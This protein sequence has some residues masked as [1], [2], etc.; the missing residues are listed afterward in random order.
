MASLE[1]LQ[2]KLRA[3]GAPASQLARIRDLVILAEREPSVLEIFL[4]GSY[5][6]GLGDR[7]SDLDLVAIAAPGCQELVLHATRQVLQS[8]S[9]FDTRTSPRMS[10]ATKG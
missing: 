7:V 9:Q 1:D 10:T 3:Q 5:A 4:V 8:G 6:K 2:S